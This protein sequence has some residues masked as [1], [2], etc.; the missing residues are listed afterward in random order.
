MRHRRPLSFPR[1]EKPNRQT[2]ALCKRRDGETQARSPHET[3]SRSRPGVDAQVPDDDGDQ[4][5][6]AGLYEDDDI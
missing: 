6:E 2:S 3:R 4:A 5:A 1:G